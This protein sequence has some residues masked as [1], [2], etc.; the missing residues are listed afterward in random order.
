MKVF[1]CA[2]ISLLRMNDKRILKI[3][4]LSHNFQ[5]EENSVVVEK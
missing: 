4:F 1:L 5:D 2:E 3:H